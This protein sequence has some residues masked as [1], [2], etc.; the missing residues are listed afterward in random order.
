MPLSK[1]LP[2]P[3]L[4]KDSAAKALA[5]VAAGTA[6]THQQNNIQVDLA[7]KVLVF[8]SSSGNGWNRE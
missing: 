1:A 5:A 2:L 6:W 3:T 4:A 8:E 7:S